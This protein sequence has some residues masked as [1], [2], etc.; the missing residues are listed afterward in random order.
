MS[1]PY[2]GRGS[3]W[4]KDGV[5]EDLGKGDTKLGSESWVLEIVQEHG[6]VRAA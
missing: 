6:T 3:Y 1:Y 5:Q 2:L 4:E